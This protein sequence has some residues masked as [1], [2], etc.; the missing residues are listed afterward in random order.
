[1]GKIYERITRIC[2]DCNKPFSIPPA[3]QKYFDE[4]EMEYPKRC[5]ECREKR[6]KMVKFT[7]IDCGKDFYLSETNVEFF[8]KNGLFIPKRCPDCINDKK[9]FQKAR[10]TKKAKEAD[11]NTVSDSVDD[12]ESF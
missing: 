5:S 2:V 1:M 7:C 3:E 11:V 4:K 8:K 6:K 9:E 12:F 10:E